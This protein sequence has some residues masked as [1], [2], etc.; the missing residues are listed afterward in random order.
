M[1]EP[2]ITISIT[3][4]EVASIWGAAM[5]AGR[6]MH[7]DNRERVRKVL[8]RAGKKLIKEGLPLETVECFTKL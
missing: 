1:S 3:I 8:E 2:R 6:F 5:I 4:K 7:Q